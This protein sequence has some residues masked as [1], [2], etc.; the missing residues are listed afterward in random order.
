MTGGMEARR[1]IA[2]AR[3]RYG[4]AAGTLLLG[5][6]LYLARP[7]D[8]VAL[9]WL[10]RAGLEGLAGGIRLARESVSLHVQLPAW[11]RGS[12]SDFAYAFSLGVLLAN[13]PRRVLALA[14]I[15]VLGH[16]IAQGLGIVAGTFDVADLAVLCGAFALALFLFRP[17]GARSPLVLAATSGET[18]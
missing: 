4:I 18:S 3:L 11:F 7:T 12:A 8:P 6:L 9:G 1:N 2:N 17:R 14:L 10:D 16:E 5:G 15:V 13:A